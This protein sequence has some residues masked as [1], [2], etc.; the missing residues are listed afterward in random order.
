MTFSV[1]TVSVV[2]HE[3]GDDI[4]HL[5]ADI[6]AFGGREIGEVIATL[7]VPEEAL[8]D[9]IEAHDWP[10]T[11][12]L[13]RNDQP[14]GYGA[15]H[16]QA[17]ARCR[18]PYFCVVNPDIRFARDPFPAL[19]AALQEPAAG[20]AYPLQYEGRGSPRDMAR[21]VPTPHAL[22][23]RYL[24]PGY[25]ARP[26]PRHWVNGAFMLFHSPVFARLGGFDTGYFMYCEDVDICLRLQLAGLRLLSVPSAKVEHIAARASRWRPRH[27]SWHLSSLWRLWRSSFYQDFM[28]TDD[29]STPDMVERLP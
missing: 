25:R 5:L 20:C 23:K 22:L 1:V 6:A 16:N 15:N 28:Q 4:P 18:T 14:L 29:L 21:E 27:M 2:S 13:I 12:S 17:F 3:H 8:S 24:L 7:N 10:F 9:W 11:V 19:I 26:Q